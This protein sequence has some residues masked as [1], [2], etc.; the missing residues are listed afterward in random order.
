M[1]G[2]VEQANEHPLEKIKPRVWP[3]SAGALPQGEYGVSEAT[4]ARH[5]IPAGILVHEEQRGQHCVGLAA[6]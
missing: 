1:P 4:V 3:G 5:S 6:M 2:F